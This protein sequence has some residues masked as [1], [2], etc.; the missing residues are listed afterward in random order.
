LPERVL[1]A[2]DQVAKDE[3]ETRSGLLARIAAVYVSKKRGRRVKGQPWK[4]GERQEH[5]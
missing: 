5:R 3:G 2:V 4:T 1:D